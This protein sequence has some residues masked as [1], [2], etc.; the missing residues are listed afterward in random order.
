[1]AAE[2]TSLAIN[3]TEVA[4]RFRVF[5]EREEHPDNSAALAELLKHTD[6]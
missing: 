1:M 6:G 2:R 4:R 5:R 3:D